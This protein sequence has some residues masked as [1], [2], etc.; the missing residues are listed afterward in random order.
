M[1]VKNL[2]TLVLRLYFILGAN[3]N[4][5]ISQSSAISQLL[6]PVLLTTQNKQ[7]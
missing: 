3:Y 6:M 1:V 7:I 4:L 5:A 2:L